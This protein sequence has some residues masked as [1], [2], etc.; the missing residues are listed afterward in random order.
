MGERSRQKRK[1]Q[2]KYIS[3]FAK[4]LENWQFKD[5]A[6]GNEIYTFIFV[7]ELQNYK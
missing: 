2:W 4:W 6:D 1:L 5:S 3:N 7:L